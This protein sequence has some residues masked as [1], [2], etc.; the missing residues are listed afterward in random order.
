MCVIWLSLETKQGILVG[1]ARFVFSFVF[2]LHA[3]GCIITPPQ[4]RPVQF[5]CPS[6]DTNTPFTHTH[7]EEEVKGFNPSYVHV[8]VPWKEKLQEENLKNPERSRC[9]ATVLTI[10][11]VGL[12]VVRLSVNMI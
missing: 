11:A 9:D 10:T 5:T 7:T 8:F 12:N 6:R 1:M 3:N 2:V 4:V